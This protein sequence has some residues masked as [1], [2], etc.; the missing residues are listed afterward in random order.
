MIL[1]NKKTGLVLLLVFCQGAIGMQQSHEGEV[2]N[3]ANPTQH[4]MVDK[5]WYSKYKGVIAKG[6]SAVL[7]ATTAG[8]LWYDHTGRQNLESNFIY[9]KPYS[10]QLSSIERTHDGNTTYFFCDQNA[11]TE[12]KGRIFTNLRGDSYRQSSVISESGPVFNLEQRSLPVRML[13]DVRYLLWRKW[14]QP[15]AIAAAPGAVS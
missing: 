8:L 2:V 7:A 13:G 4:V 11:G 1:R 5:P 6:A 12:H 10:G 14:R 3:P 9:T 15:A